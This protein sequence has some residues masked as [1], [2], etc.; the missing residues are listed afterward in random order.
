MFNENSTNSQGVVKTKCIPKGDCSSRSS[1]NRSNSNRSS[2]GAPGGLYKGGEED[3][4]KLMQNTLH[5][6][7][8]IKNDKDI[9]SQIIKNVITFLNK[10]KEENKYY[11]FVS[12]YGTF[13]KKYGPLTDYTSFKEVI[14]K[15]NTLDIIE[16]CI[17]FNFT[18]DSIFQTLLSSYLELHLNEATNIYNM[19]LELTRVVIDGY[20]IWGE[21]NKRDPDFVDIFIS[22]CELKYVSREQIKKWFS[23]VKQHENNYSDAL[24]CLIDLCLSLI[25]H[26]HALLEEGGVA[27]ATYTAYVSELVI[28]RS[29]FPS[30]EPHHKQ[31]AETEST[32]LTIDQRG[33]QVRRGRTQLGKYSPND[34]TSE[35]DS[36]KERTT[37]LRTSMKDRPGH[38][39]ICT[40]ED[41]IVCMKNGDC[42]GEYSDDATI[43]EDMSKFVYEIK[44]RS[45]NLYLLKVLVC[46]ILRAMKI[47]QHLKADSL[48]KLLSFFNKSLSDIIKCIYQKEDFLFLNLFFTDILKIMHIVVSFYNEKIEQTPKQT[49]LFYKCFNKVIDQICIYLHNKTFFREIFLGRRE[50]RTAHVRGGLQ[51]YAHNFKETCYMLFCLFYAILEKTNLVNNEIFLFFCCVLDADEEKVVLE[52]TREMQ[53][54][55]ESAEPCIIKSLYQTLCLNRKFLKKCKEDL[56]GKN[57]NRIITIFLFLEKKI[58]K[59]FSFFKYVFAF[60]WNRFSEGALNGQR[61]TRRPF[62]LPTRDWRT[63]RRRCPPSKPPNKMQTVMNKIKYV[64]LDMFT[65]YT[66]LLMIYRFHF[67]RCR[68]VGKEKEP[69]MDEFL[70]Y[71]KSIECV[72]F[73]IFVYCPNEVLTKLDAYATERSKLGK[74]AHG[75]K[76]QFSAFNRGLYCFDE[77]QCNVPSDLSSGTS[78]GVE[79]RG[80]SPDNSDSWSGPSP[81]S[82]CPGKNSKTKRESEPP[83]DECV[84]RPCDLIVLN[85]LGIIYANIME[86]LIS[87]R[88]RYVYFKHCLVHAEFVKKLWLFLLGSGRSELVRMK[89]KHQDGKDGRNGENGATRGDAKQEGVEIEVKLETVEKIDV[90]IGKD[91]GSHHLECYFDFPPYEI[92]CVIIINQLKCFS[93]D[94]LKCY[95]ICTAVVEFL[96]YISSSKNPYFFTISRRLWKLVGCQMNKYE[97]ALALTMLTKILFHVLSGRSEEDSVLRRMSEGLFT[98]TIWNNDKQHLLLSFLRRQF[99]INDVGKNYLFFYGTLLGSIQSEE[100]A[101][102]VMQVFFATFHVHLQY[103]LNVL[104]RFLNLYE[105][106]VEAASEAAREE[107]GEETGE[108]ASGPSGRA[109]RCS[110]LAVPQD[111]AEGSTSEPI[112]EGNIIS[113]FVYFDLVKILPTNFLSIVEDINLMRE[114]Q[115][116]FLFFIYV[117]DE[118][119]LLEQREE[120]H[121]LMLLVNRIKGTRMHYYHNSAKIYF[122]LVISSLISHYLFFIIKDGTCRIP[123]G[124]ICSFYEHF[125]SNP[126]LYTLCSN[127]VYMRVLCDSFVI[128]QHLRE[129]QAKGEWKPRD[130]TD[131]QWGVLKGPEGDTHNSDEVNGHGPEKHTKEEL[132]IEEKDA[133]SDKTGGDSSNQMDTLSS[134]LFQVYLHFLEDYATMFHA[135]IVTLV[136]NKIL[137]RGCSEGGSP[138]GSS[139]TSSIN[140][141]NTPQ[142][143]NGAIT[144]KRLNELTLRSDFASMDE[145]TFCQQMYLDL[146][147]EGKYTPSFSHLMQALLDVFFCKPGMISRE[148]TREILAKEV[149]PL[150]GVDTVDKVHLLQARRNKFLVTFFRN[151][152]YVQSYAGDYIKDRLSKLVGPPPF[153][154]HQICRKNL[155]ELASLVFC[156]G[157]GVDV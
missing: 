29:S 144:P 37:K 107:A 4:T 66:K 30:G 114:I 78:S 41:R 128:L 103:T 20:A 88:Y 73:S 91:G 59:Y 21:Q 58:K 145:S 34:V 31:D 60:V 48:T 27:C 19:L 1:S 95:K 46:T 133:G 32:K 116:T 35:W 17:S 76:S 105:R 25:N 129:G 12:S 28:L 120:E 71:M 8:H 57:I 125:F 24:F 74:L 10:L 80:G 99:S 143:L 45:A 14:E 135:A 90:H 138:K 94:T 113:L 43:N 157:G 155:E 38:I 64:L 84:T 63:A 136:K 22:Q 141:A 44:S 117:S 112:E 139:T 50:E 56:R 146:K 68:D 62:P 33:E 127:Q 110:P 93:N 15:I 70:L 87:H 126:Y 39:Y 109:E 151:T 154:E 7:D 47:T 130:L 92:L 36:K 42:I 108:A 77:E 149:V 54:A 89:Q 81:G 40:F 69:F 97:E 142:R 6:F 96:F 52:P 147:R 9:F 152:F 137:W 86:E 132:T 65:K 79:K 119:R 106:G 67:G 3:H 72:L 102:G 5:L 85:V 53:S 61:R 134:C 98:K 23:Y 131:H 153:G 156:V 124:L 83:S 123:S 118:Y 111:A 121:K 82:P 148:R 100:L 75:G 140:E 2:S 18:N 150:A 26:V 101:L 115:K 16:V 51:K 55:G 49:M 104:L 122:P 13:V 11:E